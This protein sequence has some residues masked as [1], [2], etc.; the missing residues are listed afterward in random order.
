MLNLLHL[1]VFCSVYAMFFKFILGQILNICFNCDLILVIVFFFVRYLTVHRVQPGVKSLRPV[2]CE[3]I[4]LF[5]TIR[6]KN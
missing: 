3:P 1:D 5:V 6:A 4:K 2:R